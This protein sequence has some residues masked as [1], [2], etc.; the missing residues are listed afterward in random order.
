MASLITKSTTRVAQ[1]VLKRI[2]HVASSLGGIPST[3]A[4]YK[5]DVCQYQKLP[6]VYWLSGLTC[7]DENFSQKAGAFQA[8]CDNKVVLVMPDT[9]PRGEGV[10]DEDPKVYDFGVGAGF[11]V[12]ATT[13]KYKKHFNMYSYITK[14][15]PDIIESNF[16]VAPVRSVSG[17]SMGG[18]GA[19]TIALKNPDRYTSVSAFAPI[20]NPM[21]VPW[22][23]KALKLYL[24]DDKEAWKQYD[25][26]ELIKSYK[27]RD[28][29][30]LC[31][32]GTGDNFLSAEVNQLQPLAF[33][34]A[35]QDAK[36][37]VTFRMQAG[38]DHSYYFMST[39]IGEHI[40]H[41]AR[42]LH[43]RMNA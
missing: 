7:T 16:N 31:D 23:T 6:V 41:H 1:G 14:E 10:P 33:M 42:L 32:Q 13:D 27:G 34:Q 22:G 2:E 19:L 28:L 26:C 36:V 12:D 11:Y 37:P 25:A 9:S 43:A 20:C 15:L 3:F 21:N 29:H 38:Y 18:H 30:I 5:P 4:V 17:H 39:F 35:A 8:A 40:A 24:G